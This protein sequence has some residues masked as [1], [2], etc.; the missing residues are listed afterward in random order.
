MFRSYFLVSYS[1]LLPVFWIN[2]G[3][4]LI[5]LINGVI[6]CLFCYLLFNFGWFKSYLWVFLFFF[7]YFVKIYCNFSWKAIILSLNIKWNLIC[8]AVNFLIIFNLVLVFWFFFWALKG[9]IYPSFC[10]RNENNTIK[11]KV[12]SKHLYIFWLSVFTFEWIV[13][14][15][16]YLTFIEKKTYN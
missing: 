9:G 2:L 4:G 7:I 3:F 12:S 14:I 13:I 5:E 16:A 11:T 8:Y 10:F 1:C 15:E 6:V